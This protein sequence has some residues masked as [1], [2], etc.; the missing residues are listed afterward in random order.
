[1]QDSQYQQLPQVKA[2]A[3]AIPK[4]VEELSLG[5]SGM[6]MGP[7]GAAMLAAAFPP[8]VRKLT[9]DLLGNRIGDEGVESISK[10]LPKSVEHLH[11]VLTENDLSK[12]GFF[13]ID[14]QIGDPLHQRHL[15]K[16]LPQNFAKGGEPEFS[17]FREAP[18]GTQV[19]QIEW[20]RAM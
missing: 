4:S 17:E 16:L 9:L 5:F 1:M 6:K 2:I 10:A 8:Q 3:A 19:T 7:S 11:I 14:R 15:P 18:D 13:M 20:H 12:R